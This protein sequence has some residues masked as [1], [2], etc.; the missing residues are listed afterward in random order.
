[1]SDL[2]ALPFRPFQRMRGVF[3]RHYYLW[4][5]NPEYFLDTIWQ[6]VVDVLI[7]GFFSFYLKKMDT[8]AAPITAFF[9]GGIVLWTILR[10][11]QHEITFS[12]ME[13]AWSR[14][15]LNILIT[16]VRM[17][18]YYGASII[19]GLLKL[20][21][22]MTLMGGL[23]AVLFRFNVLSIGA[24][25]LPFILSLLITGWALGLFVNALIIYF[26]RGL[27]ALSW[28]ISFILQPF[29]CVFYPLSAVPGWAKPVAMAF[30]ATWIFEGMRQVIQGGPMPW[31]WLFWS[32][33]LNAVLFA[34]GCAVFTAIMRVAL[35]KGLLTKLEW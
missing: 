14:N 16:P 2:T 30:P 17:A 35:A 23:I 27:V 32:L 19:F 3:R 12:L 8:T 10:R 33:G 4:V 20:A 5:R 31:K 1:V 9:L 26:G 29:A 21:V 28:I 22:E 13:E 34:A 6:P 15:L 18:E 7:W 24:A 11:G 25:L